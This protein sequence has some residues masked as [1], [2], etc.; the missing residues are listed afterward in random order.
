MS[1]LSKYKSVSGVYGDCKQ[2]AVPVIYEDQVER[3]LEPNN[4]V[5]NGSKWKGQN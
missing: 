1:G 2:L 3:L 4:I 5:Q